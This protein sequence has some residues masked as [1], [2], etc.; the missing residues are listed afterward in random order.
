LHTVA[1]YYP[2]T[3]SVTEKEAAVSFLR[4]FPVLY[5]CK[6]CAHDMAAAMEEMP[7]K[8]DTRAAFSIWM[9]ELHNHVN[10]RVGKPSF[11]CS[12]KELDETWRTASKACEEAQAK[13]S[14]GPGA[15]P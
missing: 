7:P 12:L 5:P 9:C 1:A 6:D 15:P 11:R 14:Q 4:A 10:E 2:E 3:P 13:A 8:V